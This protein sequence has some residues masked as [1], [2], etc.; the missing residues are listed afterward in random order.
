MTDEDEASPEMAAPAEDRPVED[1]P[2]SKLP[3]SR[4]EEEDEDDDDTDTDDGAV[5]GDVDGSGGFMMIASFCLY[6][7][8]ILWYRSTCCS[9][10][11]MV[12]LSSLT[13]LVTEQMTDTSILRLLDIK[14]CYVRAEFKTQL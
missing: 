10:L 2:N 12:E 1:Q 14:K 5:G 11:K 8:I 4:V 9:L 6:I 3:E 13:N 7:K